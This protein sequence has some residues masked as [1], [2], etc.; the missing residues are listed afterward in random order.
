MGR[1]ERQSGG[2]PCTLYPDGGVRCQGPCQLYSSPQ[3][4]YG[5]Y[6]ANVRSAGGCPLS[7]RPLLPI[8]LHCGREA[9]DNWT[10]TGQH[11]QRV[12]SSCS[13]SAQSLTTGSLAAAV[14]AGGKLQP[15]LHVPAPAVAALSTVCRDGHSIIQVQ[16]DEA[17]SAQQAL[18]QLIWAVALQ[19]ARLVSVQASQ[20]QRGPTSSMAA[21]GSKS[22]AAPQLAGHAGAG[23]RPRGPTCRTTAMLMVM[24][25]VAPLTS[26]ITLPEAGEEATSTSASK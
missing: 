12:H 3:G 1:F 13:C 9:C 26:L 23:S 4:S 21:A 19:Q 8:S 15:G 2:V 5:C 24:L 18:W 11:P 22:A 7:P 10:A 14:P 16:I 6:A 25:V 20:W 17:H